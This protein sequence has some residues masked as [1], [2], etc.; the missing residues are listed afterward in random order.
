MD[1]NEIDTISNFLVSSDYDKNKFIYKISFD[2][3]LDY[4]SFIIS[5]DVCYCECQFDHKKGEYVYTN[6]KR[7]KNL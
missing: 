4:M 1:K 2:D 3:W 7:R 6:K 5:D